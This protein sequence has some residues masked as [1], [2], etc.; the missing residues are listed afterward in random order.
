MRNKFASFGINLKPVNG[1]LE[2]PASFSAGYMFGTGEAP[3]RDEYM[4]LIR[5]RF[6]SIVNQSI[7]RIIEF[8]NQTD[9]TLM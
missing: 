5:G 6:K 7:C 3:K 8:I 4:Q 2:H 1:K 9:L